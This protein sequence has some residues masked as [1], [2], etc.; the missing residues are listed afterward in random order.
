MPIIQ[1]MGG[2]K[3]TQS[4]MV[5]QRRTRWRKQLADQASNGLGVAV[6]C[7]IGRRRGALSPTWALRRDRRAALTFPHHEN[8][9]DCYKLTHDVQKDRL[10]SA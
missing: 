3:L 4:A 1:G 5:Q 10:T 6:F 2:Q 9:P 7:R 8:G